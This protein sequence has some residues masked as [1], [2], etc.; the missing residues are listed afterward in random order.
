MS[1][2]V[3]KMTYF[4]A[5]SLFTMTLVLSGQIIQE[6]DHFQLVSDIFGEW[7]ACCTLA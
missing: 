1:Q 2:G 6:F 4:D 7:S 5:L 3:Q